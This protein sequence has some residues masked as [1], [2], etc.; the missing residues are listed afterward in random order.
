M[1]LLADL[2]QGMRVYIDGGVFAGS[3]G[4]I[5]GFLS[6]QVLVFI[7]GIGE[8]LIVP[9]IIYPQSAPPSN[10]AWPIGFPAISAWVNQGH[11]ISTHPLFA[12]LT[13]RQLVC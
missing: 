3:E 8:Q 2:Q 11:A 13:T 5:V 1:A 10:E 4:T 6:G 7:D 9:R 12:E